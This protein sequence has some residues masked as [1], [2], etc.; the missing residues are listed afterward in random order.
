M[1][2][3]TKELG[4]KLLRAIE[5]TN[6]LLGSQPDDQDPSA[7]DDDSCGDSETSA[8]AGNKPKKGKNYNWKN[9]RNW[10]V[11]DGIQAMIGILL[12][13][14]LLYSVLSYNLSVESRNKQLRAWIYVTEVTLAKG[15]IAAYVPNLITL[16]FKNGGVSPAGHVTSD[17]KGRFYGTGCDVPLEDAPNPPSELP[18]GPGEPMTSLQN[19]I[20]IDDR[21]LQ[22]LSKGTATFKIDGVI[23]YQDIFGNVHHTW[24]CVQY[25]NELGTMHTCPSGDDFD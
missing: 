5:N 12:I 11:A 22:A 25:S 6:V 7:G 18:V 21:C 23:D 15:P 9:L 24:V 8:I 2:S 3:K 17:F 10:P 19:A 4:E 1:D 16:H 13:G 14:N 20:T